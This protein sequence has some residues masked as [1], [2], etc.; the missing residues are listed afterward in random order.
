[1]IMLQLF[2][3]WCKLL[4]M[5]IDMSISLFFRK[6]DECFCQI[7]NS[8]LTNTKIRKKNLTLFA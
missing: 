1:M 2:V 8:P 4:L 5:L 3:F 6:E 7:P